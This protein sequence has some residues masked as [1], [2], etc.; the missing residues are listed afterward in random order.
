MVLDIFIVLCL[1]LK[2]GQSGKL[3]KSRSSLPHSIISL[4]EDQPHAAKFID[5]TISWTILDHENFGEWGEV[6]F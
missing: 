1:G 6:D 2:L 5:E 3:Y 4:Q